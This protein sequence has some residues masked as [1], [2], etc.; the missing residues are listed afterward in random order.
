M[1][2]ARQDLSRKTRALNKYSRDLGVMEAEPVASEVRARFR[3][4]QLHEELELVENRPGE[5][6]DAFKSYHENVD[7]LPMI[8]SQYRDNKWIL[9]RVHET[10][11]G[12][13]KPYIPELF[14]N[15]SSFQPQ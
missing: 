2:Q 4:H 5:L 10:A 13:S 3:V 1:D 12:L 14:Q 7:W 8:A 9:L 6:D 11:T 15:R